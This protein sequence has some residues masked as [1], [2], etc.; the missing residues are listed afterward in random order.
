MENEKLSEAVLSIKSGHALLGNGFLIDRYALVG[1][2]GFIGK[3]KL[4]DAEFEMADVNLSH[5]SLQTKH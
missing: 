2:E 1:L 5:N 4:H 3:I